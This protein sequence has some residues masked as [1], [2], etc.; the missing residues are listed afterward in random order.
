MTSPGAAS[1]GAIAKVT[2]PATS[3]NAAARLTLRRNQKFT[4][5]E[6][7]ALEQL[8]CSLLYPLRNALLY[9]DALRMAQRDPLTGI[10]NRSALDDSLQRELSHAQ[11]Q[12]SSC[13]LMIIDIDHFKSVNDNHGH[14]VGDKVLQ[15]VSHILR[16]C[17][18][19][20]DVVC[21]YGGEEFVILL[22][23]T[24]LA[25]AQRIAERLRESVMAAP[26]KTSAGAL[27]VTISL[28]ATQRNEAKTTLAQILDR[29]DQ[30]M[31]AAKRY[32]RDQVMAVEG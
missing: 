31:L 1:A 3:A 18:R 6:T 4:E 12:G 22:P 15:K 11:R 23:D 13:A 9:Q 17:L 19:D 5:T 29:A 24:T 20:S 28:G 27:H 32:G 30:G 8:L 10:C 26:I 21:R 16:E 25:Q 2:V 7:E 14:P